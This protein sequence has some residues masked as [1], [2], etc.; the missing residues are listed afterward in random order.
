MWWRRLRYLLLLATLCAI[1]TCPT[2]KRSCTAKA[3]AVEADDLLAYLSDRVTSSITETGKVPAEPAGPT[4]AVSC[5][6][7]G[8]TCPVD[9]A[10]WDTPAW[11]ALA[12]SV[13]D[14]H[15]YTYSYVPDP[16]GRAA[17]IRAVGDLDC[18]GVASTYEVSIAVGANGI[19]KRSTR[20]NPYE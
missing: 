5:C 11:K 6:D 4:P 13:D 17:T 19:E 16:A 18:D 12:F 10:I 7:Q 14:E 2:A 1:A 8:G 3:R 9:A 20:A 15:R